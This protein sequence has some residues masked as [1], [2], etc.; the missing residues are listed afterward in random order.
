MYDPRRLAH[1]LN[2]VTSEYQ[3]HAEDYQR[4]MRLIPDTLESLSNVIESVKS[5]PPPVGDANQLDAL[6]HRIRQNIDDIDQIIRWTRSHILAQMKFERELQQASW[7]LI[8]LLD[9][10]SDATMMLKKAT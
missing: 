6:H 9:E 10:S 1:L 7:R 3:R 2:L 8:R 5:L 4:R